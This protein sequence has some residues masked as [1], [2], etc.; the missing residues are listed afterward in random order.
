MKE[1]IKKIRNIGI[2]AHIDAGKTTTTERIL[3]YTGRI[4]RMGEV[5]EGTTVTDWMKQEKERG[6]TITSASVTCIWRN[7]NINIIDTPGHV[8]FTVEVERCLRVLDGVVIIFCGVGGVEPQSETVWRQADGYLIPKVVFVNKM[9][10][11]GADF[12][13][14]C[15][16][17]EGKFGVKPVV[18]FLPDGSGA[19]FDGLIDL[20][21]W[22]YIKF[23]YETLG[24]KIIESNLPEMF[25]TYA[26][27]YRKELLE[28]VAEADEKA[29]EKYL[30]EESISEEEIKRVIRNLTLSNKIVPVLA[31]S[32]LRNRGV[33]PLLDAIIDYLPSPLDIPPI[34]GYDLKGEKNQK[35]QP[36][37]QIS[38]SA[39]AFK[40]QD[41]VFANQLT[42]VR[43]YS[44]TL[45]VH[46]TVLN[47]NRNK[48]ERIGKIVRLYAQRREEIP[49]A[50]AGDIVGI[51]GLRWTKTGDTLC[52]PSKP[53]VFEKM[54]FPDPVVFVAIEA[55]SKADEQRMEE[56][57]RRLADE[58]PSFQFK[59]DEETGQKIICG[60][61]E[62]H[63]EVI[64]TRI[65][66]EYKVPI[67]VG[68]P[69]VAFRETIRRTVTVESTYDRLIGGN[70]QYAKVVMKA[71]PA[72]RGEGIIFINQWNNSEVPEN[73]F[74]AI[75]ES[76]R[77]SLSAGV[78]AGYPVTDVII[79]LVD[80]NYTEH[81]STEMAFRAASVSAVKDGLRKAE[82]IL[83]EPVMFIE[84]YT[85]PDSL[86]DVIGDFNSRKGKVE[87]LDEKGEYQ[88]IR[89]RIPL[90]QT[91]GYT[92]ALRS[93]TQGR[94][95]YDMHFYRFEPIEGTQQER[96][97]I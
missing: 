5:D 34:M 73:I 70:V 3:Y 22:K 68:K 82:P 46:D 87:A 1:Q 39:L 6:I 24:E 19:K 13:S 31:G 15:K 72:S 33:Q 18:L 44:G 20:V 88:V 58:D 38:F 21:R 52:D 53:V 78:L 40:I 42:Y 9:D 65:K 71:A 49:R 75:E 25:E 26:Q 74:K 67:N 8:D 94:A 2:V 86:G 89:G 45:N 90:R 51:V 79:T 66:E 97:Y 47:S 80:G 16:Q 43:I 23:D 76:A 32:S 10:R 14:V 81:D 4:R 63:L 7:H 59:T 17:I 12:Q 93:L 37:P 30:E 62:L 28:S 50:S 83:M 61:G 54:E 56:V 85:P 29:M 92:T 77:E 27:P 48:K 69:Q 41:D 35:R 60:M 11:M 91:F 55:K 64:A 57:L 36:N 84:I 96:A 95:T